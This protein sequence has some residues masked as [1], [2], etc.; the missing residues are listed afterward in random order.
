MKGSSV[1]V[2]AL[3]CCVAASYSLAGDPESP[4]E[5]L[6]RA[7]AIIKQENFADAAKLLDSAARAHPESAAIL[8][9]RGYVYFRW[10]KL[11]VAKNDFRAVVQLAPPALHSRYFLGRIALLEGHSREAITWLEPAAAARPPIFD[12][13]AQLGK[14]FLDANQLKEARA[15]TEAALEQTP[16]DGS[17]HYRLARIYQQLGEAQLAKREFA[18]TQRNKASDESSSRNLLNAR[19]IFRRVRMLMH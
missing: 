18:A 12:A 8:Y 16:W 7:D 19:S 15:A 3:L 13:A 10:R 4:E 1:I 6:G 17:L 2:P 5:L 14:A 9:R 11:E